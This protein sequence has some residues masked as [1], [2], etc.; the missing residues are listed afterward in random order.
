M[1]R[2]PCLSCPRGTV[3]FLLNPSHPPVGD[4]WA[5]ALGST[6]SGYTL[7]RDLIPQQG[8][9]MGCSLAHDKHWGDL[10][11]ACVS[12][13]GTMLSIY[14]SGWTGNSPLPCH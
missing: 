1:V 7:S 3:G 6:G 10:G 5:G 14:L 12:W 4:V 13:P 9:Y 2:L 11:E 8:G